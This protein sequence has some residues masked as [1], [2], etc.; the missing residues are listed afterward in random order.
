MNDNKIQ[1]QD[2]LETLVQLA[3]EQSGIM[4]DKDR[5][6]WARLV[7]DIHTKGT[8]PDVFTFGGL[9]VGSNTTTT[10]ATP[11]VYFVCVK[12][13]SKNG[14]VGIELTPTGELIPFITMDESEGWVESIV[15]AFRWR[16]MDW[17][18]RQAKLKQ[19]AAMKATLQ[20]H[21]WDLG[22]MIELFKWIKDNLP[23]P[24]MTI[25]EQKHYSEQTERIDQ[26][27]NK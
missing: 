9:D 3:A 2:F 25:T 26:F 8:P 10:S 6:S 27:L 12:G 22:E 21:E 5:F 14:Y 15:K 4:P 16:L 24:G 7:T 18:E 1:T 23:S 13:R 11:G 20:V 17:N 19:Y